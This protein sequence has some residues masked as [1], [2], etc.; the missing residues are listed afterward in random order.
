MSAPDFPG[1]RSRLFGLTVAGDFPLAAP[2]LPSP[3]PIDL[4]IS[5]SEQPLLDLEEL[6]SPP[7]Y[8]S[9]LRD[10]DG[11]SVGRLYERPEGALFHFPES[12]FRVGADFIDFHIPERGG[13]LAELRL[14]GPV[15]A[16]W[17]ELKGLLTLHASAVAVDSKAIAFV[18][19]H[20]FTTANPFARILGG[21]LMNDSSRSTSSRSPVLAIFG[22]VVAGAALL[23]DD[24]VVLEEVEDCWRLRASYPLM[25]MWP[26]EA[27]YFFERHADLPR[28]QQDSDKR[29]VAVGE[30]GFG[31]FQEASS[32]LT[33]LYLSTRVEGADTVEIQ[34]VPRSE[35]LIEL[36][37]HSFSPRLVE[38][39]GLQAAR[40]DRLARL[41]RSVPVRR[42]VYPSGFERLE[43]VAGEILRAA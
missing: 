35:A 38:A 18:S 42:L 9:A 23:A 7:V 36:V 11:V 15:L 21:L 16:Y 39:A 19:R 6:E 37:R 41:V 8:A 14:L 20:G 27:E 29:N 4:V 28:V 40:L 33:C 1:R 3:D 13:D 5:L 17:L 25:R 26:D 2:L 22:S 43:E 10:K 12:D 34:P 24:L 31:R 32:P 30:G